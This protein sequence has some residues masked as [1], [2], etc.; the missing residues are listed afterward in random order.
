MAVG[1]HRGAPRVEAL[2]HSQGA[3]GARHPWASLQARH[4]LQ[5]GHKAMKEA[6]DE[7]VFDVH[8]HNYIPRI[9]PHYVRWRAQYGEPFVY[10][11]GARP[12]ICIFDYELARQILS[13][14][15]GHFVRNDPAPVLLDAV[16]MGL[17]LLD[18]VD[19][20]HHHRVIK[21]AFAM[22]KLKMM[23]QKMVSCA[24]TM[25][26]MIT[27][28]KE[29]ED[30]AS[31]ESNSNGEIEVDFDKQFRELTADVISHTAFGSSFELG[32]EV[33]QTQHELMAINTASLFDVPIPGLKYLPTERNR[34][35][36]MLEKKLRRSLL[37]IIEPRLLASA[38]GRRGG[39]G[40]D[41]LLG[42]MLE[43]C[44]APG[45]AA[46]EHGDLSLSIDEIIDEC[47]LFFFAGHDTT[48]L[49]LTW[50]V[51]LLSAY[52]EWQERLRREVLS[53]IG[54]ERPSA[55]DLSKQRDDDG[56]LRDA[57][58]LHPCPLP[59]AEAHRRHHGRIN[60]A[61]R[62]RGG[63]HTHPAHAPRR[64]GLG[65]RRRRVQ[66]AEVRERGHESREGSARHAG[67]L[68]GA[69]VVHRP[70][71]GDAGG[72]GGAGAD[73][74]E[75]LVRAIPCLR[76]RPHGRVHAEAQVRT[77]CRSEASG[78]CMLLDDLFDM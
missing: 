32:K 72:Q 13:T 66:P 46:G 15:S 2:R 41:D 23:T 68:H 76:A 26:T 56:A 27:M 47:K 37:R 69:E 62:R 51:F 39:G 24:E 29:L 6:A 75:V 17:V 55:D 65:R 20:V 22:D 74:A 25:I 61:A 49:L 28:I 7:L 40:D 36:W 16:G 3:Q 48:S 1:L 54:R 8:D 35:R 59:A 64:G 21:P 78:R 19:W 11:F 34:R 10:W 31:K 73:A 30:Q 43:S 57:E 77:P 63:R 14:K 71:P 67:L 60:Q 12:H 52:P 53:E 70:E 18:G 33:F 58:A 45:H 42:L 9:A 50:A 5:R 44:A 38:A 4:R